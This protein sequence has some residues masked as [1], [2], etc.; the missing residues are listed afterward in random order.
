[1]NELRRT[2]FKADALERA[3][4]LADLH[5]EPW[6]LW[7]QGGAWYYMRAALAPLGATPVPPTP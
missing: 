4:W 7:Y 1:M 5:G 6:A 2:T 3:Q